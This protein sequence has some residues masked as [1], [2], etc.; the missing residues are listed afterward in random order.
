NLNLGMEY[1]PNPKLR[2]RGNI[3]GSLGRQN[4]GEGVGLLQTGVAN[5]GMA[6]SLLPGP[7]FFQASGDVVAALRTNNDNNTRN[8]RTNAEVN[9]ELIPGLRAI[10]F[11]SYEFISDIEDTFTPAAANNQFARVYAFQGR[12]FTLNNRNSIQYSKTFGDKHNLF[13]N[14]LNEIYVIGRQNSASRQERTPNDQFQGPLGFDGILSRGGG[15]L[16]NFK[17][18]RIASFAASVSYDF[19]RRYVVD[20]SYRLDG[21]SLNGLENLY[22]RNPA[23]GFRW[24]INHEPFASNW[25]WLDYGSVRLSWGMNIMPE[26][27]LED[28][29]GRYDIRGNY[30][31]QQGIGINFGRIPNPSLKPKTSLQYNLGVD[32]AIFQ[33]KV[34][35]IYDTYYKHVDNM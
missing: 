12:D 14:A 21:S 5:N 18:E 19:E 25:S 9:Y 32:F 13:V 23:V 33:N 30:N 35:V 2:F 15:V 24:N 28:I 7:S 6:S 26:G 3:F 10:S 20:L 4:K 22:S 16:T 11:V 8:I 17:D 34:E 1:N 27:R 29:Y 31:N